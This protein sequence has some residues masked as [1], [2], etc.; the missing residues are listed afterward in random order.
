MH[1]LLPGA[2]ARP[3]QPTG[4]KEK[5]S[6]PR[7]RPRDPALRPR[8]ARQRLTRPR[9]P[10]Q[11]T[12]AERLARP[13]TGPQGRRFWQGRRGTQEGPAALAKVPARRSPPV[14]A[15]RSPPVAALRSPR[16]AALRSPPVAALR[17]PRVAALRT[18]PQHAPRRHQ[19]LPDLQLR[20]RLLPLPSGF[21]AWRPL[22]P[23]RPTAAQPPA[24]CGRAHPVRL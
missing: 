18:R 19:R 14:A 24:P 6:K 2:D 5:E 13:R 22:L 23:A 17:S 3:R 9:A 12:P 4:E 16:V 20:K 8:L 10:P 21:R 11:Q 7:Q 1:Q 15:L